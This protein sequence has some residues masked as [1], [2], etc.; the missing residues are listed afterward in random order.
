MRSMYHCFYQAVFIA[1]ISMTMKVQQKT[2]VSR[3]SVNRRFEPC[4]IHDNLHS[5]KR[6]LIIYWKLHCERQVRVEAI[7][8]SRRTSVAA[9]V[10][11]ILAKVSSTY[12]L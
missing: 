2:S 11:G 8:S 10:L 5:N 1:F 7:E 4:S 3:L 12:L 6:D 9:S